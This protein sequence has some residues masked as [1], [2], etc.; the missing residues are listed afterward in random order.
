MCE[1]EFRKKMMNT[2]FKKA[3]VLLEHEGQVKNCSKRLKEIKGRKLPVALSPFA[4]YE[5]EKQGLP[6]KLIEDYYGPKELYKLGINNYKKVENI[7]DIIDEHIQN[8]CPTTAELGIRPALFSFYHLKIVYDAATIRL[9]QLSKLI[10]AEKPDVLYIYDSK[11]Y[12]FGISEMAPYLF[13]DN[14]ESIYARLLACEDWNIP[15]TVLPHIPYPENSDISK[16]TQDAQNTSKKKI[17]RW[18]RRYPE[19]YDLAVEA[20][21]HGWRGLLGGLK[22]Y[23]RAG[24][25]ARLILFGAGYD[26][27]NCRGELRSVGISPL[28]IRMRDDLEYWAGTDFF[29]KISARVLPETWEGLRADDKFRKFFTWDD[30]DFFLVVEERLRFLV[31][32]LTPACL[33]AYEKTAEIVK[34][35]KVKAFLASTFANPTTRSAAQAARNSNVPVVTWQHGSYGYMDQPMIV[36]ND[37]MN[38]DVHFVFGEGVVN[39]YVKAARRFGTRLVAVGSPSLESLSQMP[40]PDEAKKIVKLVP[41]KKVVLYASTNFY[42]NNLYV[43]FPPPFSDNDLWHTQRAILD[44]LAKHR[45]YT[46]VIKTHPSRMYRESPL[47]LYA[48]GKKF[49]NCQFVRDECDFTDLLPIADLFVIDFP[50]TTLL[51]ALTTSKPIFVYTAHLHLDTQAQKLLERHA[52]CYRE[53]KELV[54]ALDEYLSTGQTEKHVNL[55]DRKFLKMCGISSREGGS[56]TRAAKMLK[57]IMSGT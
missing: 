57:N 45:D 26:W 32:R 40:P 6:Y 29:D 24:K 51:Q 22:N 43:S 28:F 46:I 38:S 5:L 37:L 3:I 30:V 14:R 44:V 47:R 17:I 7:C 36:Y 55:N 35:G 31:E 52:F 48:R 49:E 8:A 13:F 33:N 9:F 21:T 53:L 41:G 12:P 50:S 19:L 56:A 23:L 10:D 11:R 25:G 20:H 54:N 4:M 39:K 15:V 2:H 16:K 34:K 18:L 1:K 42:Q 27:D